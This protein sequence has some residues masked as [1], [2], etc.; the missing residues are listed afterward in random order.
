MDEVE[1]KPLNKTTIRKH[2]RL[3]E[4]FDKQNGLCV[5]CKKP[6]WLGSRG[7]T[8]AWNDQ[9]TMEHIK[10]LSKGGSKGKRHNQKASCKQC[11]HTRKTIP[12]MVFLIFTQLNLVATLKQFI[13]YKNSMTKRKRRKRT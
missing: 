7:E 1:V 8:G 13:K 4:L 3:G 12:H 2:R 6:M 10:P 11:N 9:A 5:Y